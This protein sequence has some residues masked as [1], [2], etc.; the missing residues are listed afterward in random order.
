MRQEIKGGVRKQ[1]SSASLM[2][3]WE[4]VFAC[5]FDPPTHS[6][7]ASSF[8]EIIGGYVQCA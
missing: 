4:D 1:P 6:L 3:G 7:V 8:G 5:I 2:T